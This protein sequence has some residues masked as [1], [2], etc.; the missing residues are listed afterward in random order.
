MVRLC[1]ISIL[2]SISCILLWGG[3]TVNYS[4]AEFSFYKENGFDR[5]RAPK[6]SLRGE[7]GTPELPVVYLNYIIPP[8][9]KVES[10]VI[11]QFHLVQISGE[12]FIYPAQPPKVIGETL[13]WV[14]PDTIIY[15]SNNLFPGEFIK[16]V[17]EGIMDG[18]RI[19]TIEVKPLQYRPKTKKL[20][21]V[22]LIK[23]EFIWGLNILPGLKPHIRGEYEQLVYDNA[24]AKVV[25][26]DYEIPLYYQ[27]PTLVDEGIFL[28]PNFAPSVIITPDLFKPHFQPYADWLIE[29]GIKTVIVS[30]QWIYAHFS[31]C[32]NA[33]KIRNYI[34]YCY[35]EWGGTYFILGGDDYFLPVRYTTSLDREPGQPPP[36]E[37]LIPCDMYFSD[38]TG[39]WDA[40]GD[41]IWGELT[42]D[43]ADRFPEVFVGRIP[44]Y[45]SDEVTNWVNKALNY[46]ISPH[47]SNNLITVSWV[48]NQIIGKGFA[49]QNLPTHIIQRD[50]MDQY[51]NP[52]V[53]NELNTGY[54]LITIDC[55]GNIRNFASKWTQPSS[56]IWAYLQEPNGDFGLQELNNQN[57]Y[58]IC[59]SIS[60]W[61][62]AYDSVAQTNQLPSDTCIAD[63]FVD[64]YTNKGACAYLGNTRNGKLAYTDVGPSHTLQQNFYDNI[65]FVNNNPIN[66]NSLAR[67][68]VAEALSKTLPDELWFDPLFDGWYRYSCYSHNLFGS[69]Y[70]EIWTNI[71]RN[72]DV[73]HPI[74]IPAGQ[75]TNFRVRV[76]DAITN[77]PISYAKVCLNKSDDVYQ[78]GYTNGNGQV[79]FFITPQTEGIIKITVT[80]SHNLNNNYV[81]YYPSR[82][83]CL[84]GGSED[85]KQTRHSKEIFPAAVCITKFP[86]VAKDNVILK[87]NIA[88]KGIATI[89][90]YNI[91]GSRVW[92]VNRRFYTAGCYEQKIDTKKL[93]SG[94]YFIVLT[95][96]NEKIS[97]KFILTKQN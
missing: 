22:R 15:N 33:E 75:G 24:L 82:T 63:G 56:Y 5:I 70:T 55:H 12:Y 67:L 54:G 20:F 8:N 29:Q 6:F 16:I 78:V 7:P 25:V 23:F 14:P 88:K 68:G 2:L 11:S 44:A 45:N 61:C 64:A 9:A 71:P 52:T 30:P 93:S 47:S 19:V 31:G 1:K 87:Y 36:M 60:C 10:L 80:R 27:K 79:S 34:K 21:M 91:L 76:K 81:Q 90:I 46:E 59:Y 32:D 65:F 72:F 84:V 86:S 77:T 96:N 35:R 28:E 51:A 43:Q 41:R 58:Y 40:D 18:A 13:P 4:S 49:G 26:N 53:F 48:Y 97:K 94:I 39:N 38:L 3:Y 85:G 83:I 95:L 89:S 17:G 69:P 66:E 62:G 37:Y 57:K 50:C 42:Q 92:T 73:S 74:Q